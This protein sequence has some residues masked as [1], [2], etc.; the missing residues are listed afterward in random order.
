MKLSEELYRLCYEFIE[1]RIKAIREAM[2]QTQASADSETKSSAG[3]KYETGLS[4]MQLDMEK[5][6]EQLNEAV[7]TRT[8]LEQVKLLDE[9][10]SNGSG[11]VKPGSA[12]ETSNGNFYIAISAGQLKAS[13]QV[14]F[15]VSPATPIGSKLM[16][17]KTGES[18]SFNGKNFTVN[19][20]H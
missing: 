10:S 18:F 13:G 9:I 14:Y 1:N 19:K 16:G 11:V 15:A 20:I 5:Q 6:A 2:Q 17:L 7:R 4:M 12:V 8:S 3:D